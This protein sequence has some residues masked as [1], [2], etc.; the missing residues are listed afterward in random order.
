MILKK[1]RFRPLFK[2]VIRLRGNFQNRKKLLNFKKEK[3]KSSIMFYKRKTRRFRNFRKFKPLNFTRYRVTRY[4]NKGTAYKKKFR[5]RLSVKR[6]FRTFYG[7]IA[8]K[9]LKKKMSKIFKNTCSKIGLLKLFENRLDAIL[10]RAKFS[11]S[12]RG[13]GQLITRGKILVNGLNVKSKSYQIKAGDLI[14][15]NPKYYKKIYRVAIMRSPKWP[16]PPKHLL[17]HFKTM[18]IL[19]LDNFQK[20]ALSTSFLLSLK[21]QK[22]LINHL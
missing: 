22:V 3:W 15:Y 8:D 12:V 13:A 19:F 16:L 1:S 9:K 5:D 21:L 2:Q 11:D 7:G 18:Q 10:Y 4:A 17:I 6:S 20:P 14:R